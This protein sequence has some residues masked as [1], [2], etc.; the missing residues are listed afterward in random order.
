MRRFPYRAALLSFAA[1]ILV[2]VSPVAL[3]SQS[4]SYDRLKAGRLEGK[5]L[6]QWLEPDLFLFIPDKDKPLTYVRGDGSRITPGRMLTDGGSIPRPMWMLRNYS[7]WGF[8]PAFIV[9]DWIF[10][11][12]HCR[13]TGHERFSLDEAGRI[14]A[15]VMKTLISSRKVDASPLTVRAMHAAVT[16]PVARSAWNNGQC[17][18][19]PTGMTTTQPMREFEISFDIPPAR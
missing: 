17:S 9:H 14:M 15:E 12:H 2:A 16:S 19:P 11:V 6:V 4:F 10:Y 5:V 18:P 8:A 1:N 13:M 3:A 7:P